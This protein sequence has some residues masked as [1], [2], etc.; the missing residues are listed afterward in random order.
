MAAAGLIAAGYF[1]LPII[2]DSTR[3]YQTY[4]NPK[5]SIKYP[6]HWKTSKETDTSS[7]YFNYVEF[8]PSNQ[9]ERGSSDPTQ[10]E[11]FVISYDVDPQEES[12]TPRMLKIMVG[13]RYNKGTQKDIVISGIKASLKE[14]RLESKKG[15]AEVQFVEFNKDKIRYEVMTLTVN[16]KN[17]NMFDDMIESIKIK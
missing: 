13:E 7:E 16:D 3:Q 14:Y 15:T 2:K 6:K 1:L 9:P 8:V 5:F 10:Q 4:D 12:L 17:S 11:S